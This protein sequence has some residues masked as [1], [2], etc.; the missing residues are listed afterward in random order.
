VLSCDW[1][2]MALNWLV[3]HQRPI[4]SM[5]VGFWDCLNAKTVAR[6]VLA[7]VEDIILNSDRKGFQCCLSMNSGP[8]SPC[9]V[10]LSCFAVFRALPIFLPR[11]HSSISFISLASHFAISLRE[12]RLSPDDR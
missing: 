11:P 5:F 3:H 2:F 7:D 10:T 12:H 4:F 8:L 9:L 1:D 6:V